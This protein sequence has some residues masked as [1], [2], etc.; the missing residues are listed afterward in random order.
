MS[1]HHSIGGFEIHQ[2]PFLNITQDGNVNL[3]ENQLKNILVGVK[4]NKFLSPSFESEIFLRYQHLIH[5]S[6]TEGFVFKANPQF[7]FDGSIGITK[8]FTSGYRWGLFW[9]GQSQDFDYEFIRRNDKT[10]GRQS[11]LNSNIQIRFGYNFKE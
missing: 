1:I 7:M 4:Y 5:S 11:V 10:S 2:L 8:H 9:F 3:L 6:S